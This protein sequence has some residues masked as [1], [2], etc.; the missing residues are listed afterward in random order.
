MSSMP[1]A[2]KIYFLLVALFTAASLMLGYIDAQSTRAVIEAQTK[3]ELFKVVALLE[4]RLP[5]SYDELLAAEGLGVLD[6]AGKVIALRKILQPIVNEVAAVYPEY[7]MGYG[8]YSERLAGHPNASGETTAIGK[9]I[10]RRGSVGSY[11]SRYS[12]A[13]NYATSIGVNYPLCLNGEMYGHVW[14]SAKLANVDKIF[15]QAWLRQLAPFFICWLGI[16]LIVRAAFQRIKQGQEELAA[17]IRQQDDLTGTAAD[18][19]ELLPVVETVAELR[20]SWRLE[21]QKVLDILDSINDRFYALDSKLCVIYMNPKA[22]EAAPAAG[23]HVGVPF[24]SIF[25]KDKNGEVH[26]AM[27]R[28]L[29]ENRHVELYA[30]QTPHMPG[31]WFDVRIYPALSGVTLL[32][33]D[34]TERQALNEEQKEMKRQLA[35]LEEL[36]VVSKMAA[37]ISHEVRNP[38]TT[39][40]GYLQYLSGKRG[41]EDLASHFALMIEELDR[42]NSIIGDFLSIAK[43]Q[44]EDKSAG[45]INSLLLSLQP[46]LESDA[47][48]NGHSID[49]DLADVPDFA[50]SSKELKQLIFNIT[51]NAFEAMARHGTVRVST[52]AGQGQVVL[53]IRDNGPGI[54]PAV[55]E[56]LGT[57]FITTKPNGTGL[58]LSVCYSIVERHNGVIE[59]DTGEQGT[60][61]IIRFKLMA[62]TDCDGASEV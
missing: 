30:R 22:Q 29:A 44:A 39:V 13:W 62:A 56:Q 26:Q 50:F 18:F 45:N 43:S 51:R 52:R 53:T 17:R 9:E 23:T 46:L 36:N 7:A 1:L 55:L 33:S 59:V 34:V 25:P 37:S 42:A 5:R 14:A 19:P 10:Y 41:C 16:L 32:F 35:R 57:T 27:L 6:G 38:M 21:R 31:Q 3:E 40:R 4:Q 54:A 58:G 60:A 28:A 2:K 48:K 49:F 24:F 15:W 11:I 61:F 8:T 12:P 47:L 20:Q